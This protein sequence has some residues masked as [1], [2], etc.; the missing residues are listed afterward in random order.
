[1]RVMY[2]VALRSPA[3]FHFVTVLEETKMVKDA[4]NTRSASELKVRCIMGTE[5]NQVVILFVQLQEPVVLAVVAN[6]VRL[7]YSNFAP[8]IILV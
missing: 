2:G 6:Q 8:R 7:G 3:T 4:R 5:Q 1:M